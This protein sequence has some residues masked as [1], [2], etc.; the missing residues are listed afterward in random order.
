MADPLSLN[1]Q[2]LK[3]S[4]T[5]AISNET[6]RRRALGEDVYDLR[7]GEYDFEYPPGHIMRC[8]DWRLDLEASA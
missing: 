3:P 7:V 8:N 2:H 5:L 6:R 4:E 1:V